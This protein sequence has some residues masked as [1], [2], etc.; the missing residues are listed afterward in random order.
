MPDAHGEWYA[1]SKRAAFQ[2]YLDLPKQSA[3]P[4]E[5]AL[6]LNHHQQEIDLLHDYG[7]RVIDSSVVSDPQDY[8]RYIQNS[9]G[10]FSAAKPAYVRMKSGWLSDRTVCYLASGKPVIIEKTGDSDLFEGNEGMIRFTDKEE[11]RAGLAKVIADY[12]RHSKAARAL[13]EEHL[14]AKK[15]LRSVLERTL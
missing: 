4:L 14:D 2:P 13:A 7:W 10:E 1:N 15:V 12:P 11:A 5:L 3:A 8:R 6:N 9:L